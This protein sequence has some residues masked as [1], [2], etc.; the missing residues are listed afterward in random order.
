VCGGGW[1]CVVCV[2]V[3]VCVVCVCVCLCVWCVCVCVCV[4]VW[5]WVGV[6]GVCVCVC[7]CHSL[8]PGVTT[9][10]YTY[11][12]YVEVVRLGTKA[13]YCTFKPSA[14]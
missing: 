12:D 13:R 5:G 6:C 4:R 7:V 8:L 1:V 14:Q 3:F 11:H 9:T 2:C 10:L